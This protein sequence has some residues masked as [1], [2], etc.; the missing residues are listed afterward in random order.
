M[1]KEGGLYRMWY[2]AE[3]KDSGRN[4][5]G[6]AYSIDGINWTKYHGNPIIMETGDSLD[7]DGEGT[8]DPMVVK[9][10]SDHYNAA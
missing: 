3:N 4:R 5:I 6:Y 8:R 9:D 2:A 10:S 1:I 7:F